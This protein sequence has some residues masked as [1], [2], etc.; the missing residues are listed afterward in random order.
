MSKLPE[1]YAKK[2][3][4][5]S[6]GGMSDTAVC[7]DKNLQRHVVVKTL[8]QG[9]EKYRLMDELAALADIRSKYVVQVLD[10]IWNEDEIVGFVEEYIE[11]TELKP[12]DPA[13]N[14]VSALRL[15]YSII[16]GIADI[17]D[18]GRVHRDIKPD[19]M[20]LDAAGVLK[21]FDFGLAK[22]S[23]EAKTQE[24]YFTKFYTAPE[25]FILD[26]DGNH[27]FTPAVDVFAFGVTALWLLNGGKL[28]P[29]LAQ[30][31]PAV[32]ALPSS[33]NGVPV[34]TSVE[35][36]ALLNLC[37]SCD[38]AQ[39][40]SALALKKGLGKQLLFN[41][42]RM[43]ITHGG[44]DH[45]VDVNNSQVTLSSGNDAVTI[46]YNGMDFVVTNVS[47][48][49]R[50]NNTPVAVGFVLHGAAVIVLGD[51]AKYGRTSITADISHPE[52]MN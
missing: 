36:T 44:S 27:N 37:L 25:V 45:F 19:N 51:P 46:T 38:P 32:P 5:L 9:I 17:H 4:V 39:R 16:S 52:V 23:S 49:V 30:I 8:K 24:L 10:V 26:S 2:V 3:K 15:L 20:K 22:L 6:G 33:F 40:P 18:S 35:V 43:L 29:E 11:G 47:G 14:E 42:H 50:H 12:L 48:F 34:A 41:K 1:R 28:I 13:T 31:P 21:I 7:F